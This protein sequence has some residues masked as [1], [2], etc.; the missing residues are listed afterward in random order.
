MPARLVSRGLNPGTRDYWSARRSLSNRN[1]S[2]RSA[3]GW[4]SRYPN[5]ILRFSTSRSTA[6]F[7]PA[8][9]SSCGW[10]TFVWGITCGI[11]QQSSK[12]RLVGQSNLRSQS[13]QEVRLKLGYQRSGRSA[14]NICSQV[15]FMPVPTYPR[16]N[17]LGW[18]IIGSRA[19]V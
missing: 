17:I 4:K 12:R 14:R 1:M 5:V 9:W 16:A 2:G 15:A 8:T 13:N 3:F 10:T 18:Y 6:N 7:A 19:S 11:E